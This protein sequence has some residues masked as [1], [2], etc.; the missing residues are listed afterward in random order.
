MCITT[1]L[2][3]AEAAGGPGPRMDLSRRKKDTTV[4][5]ARIVLRINYI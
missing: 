3:P 4:R 1:V 5:I 2:F